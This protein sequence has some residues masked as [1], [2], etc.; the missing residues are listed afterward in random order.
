MVIIFSF[1]IKFQFN[2]L[3]FLAHGKLTRIIQSDR[4][5]HCDAP[6]GVQTGDR[7]VKLSGSCNDAQSVFLYD[8]VTGVLEHACSSTRVCIRTWSDNF[9][10][11]ATSCNADPVWMQ[12]NTRFTR[13]S[14][15]CC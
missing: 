7:Y 12:G 8:K 4:C 3:I 1:K 10:V 6:C 13:T 14:C 2:K 5:W 15:K 9:L 11:V